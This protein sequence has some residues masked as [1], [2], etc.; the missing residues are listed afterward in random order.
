MGILDVAQPNR[1]R[2]IAR[3]YVIRPELYEQPACQRTG[4]VNAIARRRHGEGASVG[5]AHSHVDPVDGAH[6][7]VLDLQQLLL[8]TGA[9]VLRAEF[10][11]SGID[12]DFWLYDP[13]DDH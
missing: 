11:P 1:D 3:S 12:C 8:G 9:H 13:V 10:D 5:T 6:S 4:Y 2:C 7:L